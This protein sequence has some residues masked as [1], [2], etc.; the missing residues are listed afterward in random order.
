MQFQDKVFVVTGAASG[1]GQA[2]VVEL[3]R[4]GASVAASDL[5]KDG[6]EETLALANAAATGKAKAMIYGLDVSD[7]EAWQVFRD[8]AVADFG[9]VDGIINNAGIALSVNGQDMMHDD[10]E[11]VM[12]V[13]FYGMVYGSK[14]FMPDIQARP[15]AVIA[16]VSSIFGLFGV[17]DQSAY[18]ASKFAIRGYTESLMQDLKGSNIHVASIH[19]GHIGTNILANSRTAGNGDVW[20][21]RGADVKEAGRQFR[22][23]GLAP[24]KAANI[25]LDGLASKKQRIMVGKDAVWVNRLLSW[26]PEWMP[27]VINKQLVDRTAKELGLERG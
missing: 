4:R 24:A 21:Q 10:L 26:F 20:Q 27:K 13:N 25:I 3:V 7:R 19:P 11:A 12:N 15:E 2:L 6:L 1:I 22:Q 17:G 8:Q 16:N 14:C 5:N 9:Q 18:C 23:R